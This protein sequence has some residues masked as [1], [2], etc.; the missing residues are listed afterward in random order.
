VVEAGRWLRSEGW[1]RSE[2]SERLETSATS[3]ISETDER[4]ETTDEGAK[5]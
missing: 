4:L 3:A 1:S 5:S 2:R